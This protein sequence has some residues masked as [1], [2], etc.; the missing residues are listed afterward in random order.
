MLYMYKNIRCNTVILILLH[1]DLIILFLVKCVGFFL[2]KK[3]GTIV[4]ITVVNS[5]I[6][7][8]IY[9]CYIVTFVTQ[10]LHRYLKLL[11]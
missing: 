1:F 11:F 2:L 5:K 3:K 7:I 6:F 4:L 9:M 8:V 10:Y